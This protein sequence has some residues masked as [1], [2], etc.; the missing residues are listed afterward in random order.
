MQSRFARTLLQVI[1]ASILLVLA[2]SFGAA[3]AQDGG[4]KS[5]FVRFLESSLSTP[6]R[7]I[8]LDGVEDVF[9]WNP[10]IARITVADRDG[11]SLPHENDRGP[12]RLLIQ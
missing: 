9:S 7:K 5:G 8:S 10:K 1:A 3:D 4:E 2:L 11:A 12:L 6:D